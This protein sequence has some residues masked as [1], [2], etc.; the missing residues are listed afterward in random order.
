MDHYRSLAIQLPQIQHRP[1]CRQQ[2][3]CSRNPDD[4]SE[5]SAQHGLS[6]RGDFGQRNWW[7]LLRCQGWLLITIVDF[8]RPPVTERGV[9]A[10][11]VVKPLD[12]AGDVAPGL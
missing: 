6:C 3:C 9:A 7:I 2:Q 8:V 4:M 10:P 11:A 1:H 5:P 12:V